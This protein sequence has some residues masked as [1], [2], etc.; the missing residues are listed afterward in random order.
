MSYRSDTHPLLGQWSSN[1]A[2]W[3]DVEYKV[4]AKG[5]SFQVV[6]TDTY[7]G[8]RAEISEVL[9]DGMTLAFAE[10]WPSGRS[11]RCMLRMVSEEAA[12]IS[13]T[14]VEHHTLQRRALTMPA[15][16]VAPAHP[17][18]SVGGHRWRGR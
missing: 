16:V 2:A 10:R 12:E 6:A 11:A 7:T 18:F 8:E 13:H 5:A 9:W 3:A 15:A 14:C 4:T 17:S 1:E